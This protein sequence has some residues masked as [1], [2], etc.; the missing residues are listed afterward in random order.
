MVTNRAVSQSYG[1]GI[2]QLK[3][4]KKNMKTSRILLMV[5]TVVA[6][7]ATVIGCAGRQEKI[8]S[9]FLGTYPSFEKG[10]GNIDWRYL[11]P[12]IDFAKYKHVMMNEV[13]FYFDA[14]ADYKGIHPSEI[15]ELSDAFHE[16][17]AQEL[18]D[19]LTDKPGPDV[20][21]MRLAVTDLQTSKPALGTLTTFI[22]VGLGVS[23][24]KKGTT[25]EY[26]GVGSATMEAEFLDSLSNERV[27]A[28]MD[29]YPGGKLDVGKLSAAKSA[30][31]YWA[32]MLAKFIRSWE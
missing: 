21:L 1:N 17:F 20:A 9:G 7:L 23:L 26:I 29:K 30:F 8:N 19:I 32:D 5:L 18:G 2:N 22:P 27:A 16:T 6:F 15:K 4:R 13:V 14:D 28:G 12:G 24:V 31:Q 11:K 10:A 3:E 25:G